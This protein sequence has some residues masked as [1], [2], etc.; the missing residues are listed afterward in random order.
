MVGGL[1]SKRIFWRGGIYLPSAFVIHHK[2]HK[3]QE[4][5]LLFYLCVLGDLCGV[6]SLTVGDAHP[7]FWDNG[8]QKR[9]PSIPLFQ[10]SIIPVAPLVNCSPGTNGPELTGESHGLNKYGSIT[11]LHHDAG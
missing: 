7:M 3:D 2:V 11:L 4:D 10:H 5:L 1:L 6:S 9:I 8:F